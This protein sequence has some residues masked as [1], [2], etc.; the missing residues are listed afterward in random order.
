LWFVQAS[1]RVFANEVVTV[2]L[3]FSFSG[4]VGFSVV[5]SAFDVLRDVDVAAD[6][7]SVFALKR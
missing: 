4:C 7:M 3:L 6:E 2:R 1:G 5:S